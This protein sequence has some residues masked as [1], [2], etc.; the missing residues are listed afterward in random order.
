MGSG[1]TSEQQNFTSVFV[2]KRIDMVCYL[3]TDNCG[4]GEI[5]SIQGGG[6]DYFSNAVVPCR[7]LDV[8]SGSIGFFTGLRPVA[9]HHLKSFSTV[10]G[11]VTFFAT[12]TYVFKKFL[13]D[14]RPVEFAMGT[15]NKAVERDVHKRNDLSHRCMRGLDR[16]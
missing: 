15:R 7:V 11:T 3:I 12:F 16:V 14:F 8:M 10:Q 9:F 2:A 13:I 5:C 1:R 4:I 6:Q